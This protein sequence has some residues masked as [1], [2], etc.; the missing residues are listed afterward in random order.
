MFT[1]RRTEVKSIR[2]WIASVVLL[3]AAGLFAQNPAPWVIGPFSRPAVGNPVVSPQPA[4]T[5]E[6]PILKAP[7]QWEALHTFN[8]AAIVRHGKVYV[9]YRAEDNSGAMEI[10]GHTSRLG[11]AESE[12]G[13]HFKR[14]AAPVFYPDEDDQ[15]SREWPGGVEDPRIVEREDG[16]YV[17]TYTQWN[18][19][20]YSVGIATSTDLKHWT[21]H[22]P[23]FFAAA[24]GKYADLK[25]KSA[26]ILTRLVKDR[27]IAAKVD[28]RYWMY[29]GEGAIHL[30]TSADLIH[31]MPVE[32]TRGKLVE[33]LRPRAGHFDSTFPET[34]P[35]PVVTDAG[36]VVLYN[37]KNAE[38]GGDPALGPN[39][40]A[41]G[42]ARFD[43]RNPANLLEQT[44]EPVLKPELPYEKTGQYAA[45]TTFAE[46]LVFFHKQWFLYYGCADSLVAV[47]TAPKEAMSSASFKAAKHAAMETSPVGGSGPVITGVPEKTLEGA[48]G[49]YL[50]SGDTVV[51]YGDSITEENYY[52]Q[53]V[54]LYTATRFPS[55]RVHFYGAGVGGDRVTGG[56]GGPID[57]RLE[58]DVFSEKP[59]VVT[60][61]LGM[62]DG[63]YRVTTPEIES[64]YVNGYE[65][66]LQ[67]IHEHAPGTRVTL[68]GPSPF[69]DVT[70]PVW[71]PGGYNGAM[72]HFAELD[73]GLAKKY[74]GTFANLN[75]LVVA[76][77]E[78]ANK[79]DPLVAKLLLPDRVHP[80]PPAHWVMAEALL[81]GWN[82]PA[83]VS[84]VVID[85]RAGK[86]TEARNA[87]V[88]QVEQAN[89]TL[90][91]TETENALPLP[92]SRDNAT[93]ALLLN[94]TDIEQQLDQEP[95]RVTG[96][97]A[98]RYTMTID[99]DV[100][101]T[102]S[103]EE[104]AGGINLADYGTP[105][106]H[107]AQR[108]SWL[109]RDRD[110]AHY[111]HLRMRV[112]NENTGA[113]E[114]KPDVMQ[115]FENSLED[116]IYKEAAPKA[117]VFALSP[118][119]AAP[120][121]TP[122]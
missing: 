84:S 78:K 77:L 96:L 17:L 27:L 56:G 106:F 112:R 113:Q 3:S 36:I 24:G 71:F 92:L 82:A 87:A 119:V 60:V 18:R 75:P 107:Q 28:G 83:L 41:A 48:G 23:A 90:K 45:G 63:S 67:S 80:D 54:E 47:A 33:V 55:M 34:G 52:N 4:S 10:G 79:L 114:G 76:A 86:T 98:G 37:G 43:A 12:D 39:A 20:A 70:R 40:Y 93:Q 46:G 116:S 6:D 121:Q 69:D 101:G 108:V 118:A 58:R 44:D 16:T 9:L 110:E 25:H 102:F 95:L 89:G 49:F 8:P 91:W 29:W 57:Q 66:L 19:T 72:E 97:D 50:K 111:I 53:W 64:T 15:K 51:F 42:E 94:L 21:K 62:N 61:M 59:T 85:G 1:G 120:A 7:A 100:V 65:H 103:A 109:V 2:N 32:N 105:M 74:G 122:Q 81:K 73:K 14:F 68:L 30:A 38:S 22:G 13:I 35:P 104:L 5:F 99:G 88:E 11:L 115:A 117:H 31:W 26:G